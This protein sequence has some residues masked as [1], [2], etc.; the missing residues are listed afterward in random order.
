MKE[1]I[2]RQ[3][4]ELTCIAPVHTGS[5]EKRRAFEYL[6]DSR[7]NEVAFPNESKWIVL[8]AQCGLMDDFAHAIEQ[9]AFREK[10]L[11]EWLLANG[12]KEGALRSIVL[13]KAATPDLMTTA[14]GRRSLND[15]V[16]QTTHADGRPY[17]PGSTIKGALRTGLLYGAVRRDPMQFRSFWARIRAEAGALRDK[18]K[19][20]S[21]IIE[22]M[23]RTT[24]HTLALPGAKASDAVSSA[25]RGLRVSDAVGT[26]AMDTIVLQKV[27]ATTKRNKAGKNESR[28]PLFRECIPAGRTLRFSI[29]ADL[30][31]LETA[32]IMSLDQVMESLRDYTSD[33][34]RLQKQVFLPMNPRFYQPLFEEAE[35][36]DMLLGGGTGF[37]AK[38]LVYALADSDE[39]AREFIAAYLDEQFAARDR[40]T[41]RYESTHKHK[42]FDR[43]LSPRTLKRA[44]MGQD[45]WI[46]GLCALRRVD[47][48]SAV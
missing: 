12:V 47:D 32:G 27:D 13:R 16:C 29:T 42:Q 9:G 26:G 39:E 17:I 34:L 46:M 1:Q 19:A 48:V 44:V 28:L 14:R 43:T 36:A 35:T 30:A 10:S 24:L 11:R 8:L 31:M 6:Y 15:I 18:K 23:E 37:L 41:G 2:V 38:T 33:G 20:W 5:G 4:Y 45:D 25:L 7:K 22:E 21:R 40:R 3:E